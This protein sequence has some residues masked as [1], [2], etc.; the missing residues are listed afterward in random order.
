MNEVLAN[1][2]TVTVGVYLY[3]VLEWLYY[4]ISDKIWEFSS[5]KQASDWLDFLEDIQ[6]KKTKK[7]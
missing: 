2:L 1:V 4:K 6:E 3:H 7:K 5:E